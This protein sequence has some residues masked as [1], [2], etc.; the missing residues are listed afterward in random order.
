[1]NRIDRLTAI[2]IQLQSR[3]I[4]K[5]QDI[6][7]R[8]NISLRTVYRDIKA[9][10][11]SGVPI[12]GEA[13]VG[14]SLMAGYKLPPVMFTK[15]EAVAFLTAEKL[16]HGFIDQSLSN[17]FTSGVYKIKAILRTAERDLLENLEK[18]I[19]VV[20]KEKHISLLRQKNFIQKILQA[21]DGSNT[22]IIQ[23][24]NKNQDSSREIDPI[25]VC[26]ILEK[27]HV[28]AY[29][30]MRKDYRDFRIDR[31]SNLDITAK[32][33][34]N[35]YIS[36]KSYLTEIAYSKNLLQISISVQKDLYPKLEEQKYH[37][38]LVHEENL[39]DRVVMNFLVSD[40]GSMN[41]WILSMGDQVTILSP[42]ELKKNIAA[43]IRILR[44]HY[45]IDA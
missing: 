7:E 1:M 35:N 44:A 20:H 3:R 19:T 33:F 29:C 11:E 39:E 38:G 43:L 17:D 5:A 25:G 2:L 15:E 6:A 4:I 16:M 27:W 18:H 34:I 28:I 36:L 40:L 32:K 22:L 10:E 41:G 31:I 24:T 37:Y 14:Y 30:H 12:V 13:G 42:T 21:I 45:Q 23:Y 8:F 9:L 26:L